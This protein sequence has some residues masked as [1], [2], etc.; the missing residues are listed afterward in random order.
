[1]SRYRRCQQELNNRS[2]NTVPQPIT[3]AVIMQSVRAPKRGLADGK[4]EHLGLEVCRGGEGC[5]GALHADA[6][7][8]DSAVL[9]WRTVLRAA[10]PQSYLPL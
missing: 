3:L 2:C 4:G 5:K 9:H 10:S 1:M 7:A 8:A 6:F